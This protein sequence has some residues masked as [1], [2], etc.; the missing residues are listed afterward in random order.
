L[1]VLIA[2]KQ[3][4]IHLLTKEEARISLCFE[5]TMM[6]PDKNVNLSLLM[7][8]N[9]LVSISC[10]RGRQVWIKV[11][12]ALAGLLFM[13]NLSLLTALIRK[14]FLSPPSVARETSVLEAPRVAYVAA[15][16]LPRRLPNEFRYAEECPAA[17]GK[18]TEGAPR[19]DV[20]KVATEQRKEFV[21]GGYQNISKGSGDF[22]LVGPATMA[23][24]KLQHE[25][26]IYGSV[27][28]LGVHHGRFTGA[29]FMTARETEKLIV[30]DLFEDL[31]YQN[32]DVSGFGNKQAF[33]E[34]IQSYGLHETDLHLIHTGSTEDIPFKW[35]L[36]EK[37]EPFRLISVD[38][39]HT[40]ALTFNDLEIAFCNSLKGAVIIL[41][42]FFHNLWPGVTEGFFQFAGMGPVE[43]VYPFLR[44][45]GKAFVTN[46]K[47]FHMKY[48][49]M[50]RNEPKF[51]FFL[52]AYAHKTR[53]AKVK[54]M[55]NG[56]EYLKCDS[57]LLSR[58]T[59]HLL[60][61]SLVY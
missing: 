60:W 57:E 15:K 20:P 44:C 12:L 53:G 6:N 17:E 26:G 46:D 30:A 16:A 3:L 1:F 10:S 19:S 8:D 59:M 4:I 21:M 35:H 9:D 34:G 29:L 40:A 58:E 23:L 56:V 27:A 7:V 51:K 45:E 25:E 24:S 13:A 41:D 18:L 55:M 28:E 39:G 52:N 31:Q 36:E 49:K 61:T 47:E 50:L 48:Y 5:H 14:D 22:K 54:Y 11:C 33:I 43:G 42:D 32:V 38:A 2:I 37:F